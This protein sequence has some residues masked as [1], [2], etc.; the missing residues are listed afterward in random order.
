MSDSHLRRELRKSTKTRSFIHFYFVEQGSPN[1]SR[2]RK[3]VA[4]VRVKFHLYLELLPIT[5]IT[6]WA[7]PPGS[8]AAALDSYRSTNPTVNCTHEGSRVR[9]PCENLMPDDLRWSWGGDASTREQLQ[10][11][12]IISREVWLHRD[13]SLS[14]R[15]KWHLSWIWWQAINLPPCTPPVEKKCFPW[16]QSLVPETLGT[17]GVEKDSSH[18]RSKNL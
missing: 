4:E 14:V 3:W 16:K 11:K 15:G 5:C 13:K 17:A 18:G 6:A 12:V 1:P 7:P 2:G 9:T 8:S 10:I